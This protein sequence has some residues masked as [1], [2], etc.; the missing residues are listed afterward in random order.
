MTAAQGSPFPPPPTKGGEGK[1]QALAPGWSHG[2]ACHSPLA[3]SQE[4]ESRWQRGVMMSPSENDLL[5]PRK[6]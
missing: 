6:G 3:P 5:F 2:S 4:V 1:F